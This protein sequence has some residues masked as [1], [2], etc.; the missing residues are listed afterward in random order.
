MAQTGLK[1][2]DELVILARNGNGLAFTALW[3]RHIDQLRSYI[4]TRFK[5]ID[6]YDVDDICSRSFEKAFRQIHNYDDSKSQFLTWL[7]TI[8]RNTTLDTLD[9][10]KR[11]HPKNQI[12]YLDDETQASGL[13]GIPD[14]SEDALHTLIKTESEE[15]R[16][17]YIDRLPELYREVARKRLIDGM[18]YDEIAEN[19]DLELNTVKTRIRRAKQIIDALRAD[20]EEDEGI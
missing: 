9:K 3:D 1:P 10:E 16:V 6:D 18:K 4:K 11:I 14:Q 7:Y 2:I 13:E 5:N 12:V 15:E 20:E 8:A 17:K 19:M